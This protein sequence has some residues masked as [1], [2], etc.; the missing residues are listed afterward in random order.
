L[1]SHSHQIQIKKGA[2]SGAKI[3]YAQANEKWQLKDCNV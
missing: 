2:Q 3:E 1:P